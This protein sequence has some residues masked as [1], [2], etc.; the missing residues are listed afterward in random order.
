MI[1]RGLRAAASAAS[2]MAIIALAALAGVTIVDVTGRN[3]LNKP[4]FGSIEMSEFLLV[5][6]GFGGLALAEMRN[7]H[8]RVDFFVVAL[9]ARMQALLEAAAALLGIVFWGF[10]AWRAVVHARRIAEVG[11][12]SANWGVPTYPFYLAT[13]FGSALLA[14]VLLARVVRALREGTR[15][16]T[17]P[18]SA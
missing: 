1:E 18:P 2:V 5:L 14:A 12:V 11:E 6:L 13:A 8:I 17:P 15:I 4:V 16:W 3:L 9:P 10:I 7:S